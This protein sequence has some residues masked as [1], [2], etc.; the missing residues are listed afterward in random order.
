MLAAQKENKFKK[1]NSLCSITCV[2]SFNQPRANKPC[3]SC[4]CHNHLIC[5]QEKVPP[6]SLNLFSR[7][8]FFFGFIASWN[9]FHQLL[10]PNQ[11]RS[12]SVS[13]EEMI[14]GMYLW[15]IHF[16]WTCCNIT[17]KSSPLILLWWIQEQNHP[18]QGLSLHTHN[19]S[20]LWSSKAKKRKEKRKKKK[21][22]R[23]NWW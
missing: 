11:F 9:G 15:G 1:T 5:L 10:F 23:W 8:F 21:E 17:Y 16:A 3:S 2:K 12:M 22:K 20:T 7:F 4:D 19:F 18:I 6:T 13:L 14:R